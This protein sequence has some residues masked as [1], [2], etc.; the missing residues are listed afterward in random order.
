MGIVS[1][2]GMFGGL[3]LLVVIALK[4]N[5][6]RKEEPDEDIAWGLKLGVAGC[7]FAV[8]LGVTGIV[9]NYFVKIETPFDPPAA[10]L[11]AKEGPKEPIEVPEVKSVAK[12]DPMKDAKD[13]HHK[14]L[15]EFGKQPEA[16]K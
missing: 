2:L 15:D 16:D 14:A 5:A 9:N 4:I 8:V 12:P 11:P 13:D 10:E 6:L 3:A 1:V 7:L